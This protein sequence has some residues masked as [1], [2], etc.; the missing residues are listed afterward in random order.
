MAEIS[1]QFDV[2]DAALTE[3]TARRIQERLTAMEDVKDAG[4]QVAGQERG[5]V[6]TLAIISATVL[7]AKSGADLV[8]ALRRLVQSLTGLVGDIRGLRTAFVELRGK[9]VP[10]SDLTE[11]KIQELA[12]SA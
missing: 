1:L 12:A 9:R 7:I 11:E 8:D 10:V 3:E 2:E 5:V 4:A 6:E